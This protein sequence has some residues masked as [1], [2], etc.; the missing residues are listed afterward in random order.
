MKIMNRLLAILLFSLN[1]LLG[2]SYSYKRIDV[3]N[4]LSNNQVLCLA[5]DNEGY[6]WVGTEAGLNRIGAGFCTKF[7]RPQGWQHRHRGN[8]DKVMSLYYDKQSGMLFVGT[9]SGL[10]IVE[11]RT[12][13]F[14]HAQGDSL[15]NYGVQDMT[16]DHQGGVWLFYNNGQIQHVNCKSQS[17]TTLVLKCEKGNRSGLDD[18]RG[19]LY[20]GH[21]NGGMSI[22]DTRTGKII[23]AYVHENSNPMSIPGN[24]VRR[25]YQDSHHRIWVGT[26]HGLALFHPDKG[27]FQAIRR[28][29]NP[30]SDNVFDIRE[31]SDGLLYVVCDVGGISIVDCR[32]MAYIDQAP[33]KISS[34]NSRCLLEDRYG[35]I[36]IGSH[37]T[38][39]DFLSRKE[40]LLHQLP[41]KNADGR[42]QAVYAVAN[43][44]LGRLWV[45]GEDEISLWQGETRLGSWHISGLRNR[46]HSYARSMMVDKDGKV[47]L[48]M[49]DEGVIRFDPQSHR[50][51]NIDI[52]Y[53]APD[54]HSFFED[55][56]GS[57]W[58]GSEFGICVYR[59][60]IVSHE[61]DIDRLI[62]R[63][64]VTSFVRLGE[65]L[66]M[67]TQGYGVMLYNS[68][69]GA[70]R[71][72]H[73]T[74]GLPTENINQA[75]TDGK[76]GVWLATNK[77]IVFLP[78]IKNKDSVVCYGN[79]HEMA[80]NQ[81]QAIAL[82]HW[83]RLWASTFTHLTCLDGEHFHNYNGF[84]H[85][86]IGG[87][88]TGSVAQADGGIAFG[89]SNGV[90]Y[91][92]PDTESD[93]NGAVLPKIAVC[94]IWQSTADG[95]K[96]VSLL[97]DT[98][99]QIELNYQQNTLQI[100]AT[101][102]NY[103]QFGF[104]DMSYMMKG[105]EDKWY[106]LDDNMEVTFRSLQPGKYT[107]I[108]KAKLKNQNWEEARETRLIINIAPPFWLSWWAWII[109]ALLATIIIWYLFHTYKRRL[110]LQNLLELSR[111]E[112]LQK[113]ELNEERLRFFTNITHEL[114]TPLTLILGPLEDLAADNSL[115]S[116][117]RRKVEMINKSA[118]RLR[119]LIN[120]ILEFRKTETQ[121]RRL[122]VAQ[123]DIGQAVREIVLNYRELNRN[124]QVDIRYHQSDVLPPVYFDS[125]VISTILNNLLSNAVKYTGQGSIEVTV[126]N[127][128]NEELLIHVADTG[129]GIS[130]EA[131]PHIFDRYYQAK[132]SHQ[133]SGTG[134]GLSLV[135]SLADL[136]EAQIIVQSEE[137]KGCEFVISLSVANTYPNA[138]HKEDDGE[139]QSSDG[140]HQS[141]KVNSEKIKVK[142]DEQTEASKDERPLL[143]VVEDN[144][145]IR[146]Y[147]FDSLSDDFQILQA[148][149]GQEGMELTTEHQPD[150]IVSDIMMPKMNGIQMTKLIK[151]NIQTCHIPIILLTAKD[152]DED[153]EEGYDI[154]ADSYL[155]KPFTTK[156]L[157]SRIRNL[158]ASRRRL[159]EVLSSNGI[160]GIPCNTVSPQ[161]T[162]CR[163]DREFMQ[164]LDNTIQE[165]IMQTDIDMA[166]LTDKMSMSHST[167]YR[168]VKA[169][170]GLTAK[171]YVRKQRLRHCYKLLES[172]DYN[173]TEA[174]MM[175]GF[176]QMAHFREV[177]KKEFGILPSELTKSNRN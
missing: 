147:I 16:T 43:D 48:G 34:L 174:A 18:G 31:M 41:Y 7:Y 9:E 32:H 97:P 33:Y 36:W 59:N 44:K 104:V 20:I 70:N 6:V 114:R 144:D 69:T 28:K 133:A 172:G 169:L 35:N 134:I 121:N 125:E 80:D 88:V 90:C 115:T 84:D 145:D 105:L 51:E 86:Q 45:N 106:D 53:D 177:F 154:G 117:S 25:I 95:I 151:D 152:T 111:R 46:A 131:L 10:D 142:S 75:L 68:E 50:F 89:S 29:N 160:D 26:D 155:T 139:Y 61:E 40:P 54:I 128:N 55:S 5:T 13:T 124:P 103:A 122:T 81:V 27:V 37:S 96:A 30:F 126:E 166:F 58:I 52:G 60:G 146:Q 170:T 8:S 143:L 56:D 23:S 57:V 109:Y 123:G 120:Q 148:R 83:G 165:H 113:Q 92:I 47:W 159:A 72:L 24:N 4:G 14:R 63:A 132:G 99:G 85:L 175:T 135:K 136:H 107:F 98:E 79:R 76:G 12:G 2:H 78:D 168:K 71:Q 157:T 176:N 137:G 163:L 94:N 153:K 167:F 39:I 110:A 150:L 140:E 116:V 62:H 164:R 74:D 173:V 141:S 66:L 11:S 112:S 158:L 3:S 93:R 17:V 67:T 1:V 118:G 119:D 64:P 130:A 171:E 138:L 149:D 19:H 100:V 102:D 15:L 162:L 161:D 49:E 127:K 73:L 87:F 91:V 101:V 38:G 156:L 108:L 77:G 65:S 129:Y 22:V 21:G 42:L 82:D